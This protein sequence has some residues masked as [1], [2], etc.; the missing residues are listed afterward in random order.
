MEILRYEC[1][2][3]GSEF[4]LEYDIMSTED[5]PKFCPFCAEYL[6]INFDEDIENDDYEDEDESFIDRNS[7]DESEDDY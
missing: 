1:N 2:S 3:C 4:Q 7:D 5:D 6:L